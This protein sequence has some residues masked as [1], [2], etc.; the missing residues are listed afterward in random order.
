MGN[1]I[2]VD[3]I[4]EFLDGDIYPKEKFFVNTA[5]SFNNSING[6][7]SFCSSKI[8]GIVSLIK[9]SKAS[10]LI[11]DEKIYGELSGFSD[12]PFLIKSSNPRLDFA[13]VVKRFFL[14]EIEMKIDPTAIISSDAEIDDNVYIGPLSTIGKDVIIKKGTL[15]HAGVHIYDKVIIGEN[16]VIHSGTVIGADGFGYEKNSLGEMEKIPHIG[17]IIIEDNV[18]IGANTCIDRGTLDDTII[19]KGAKI[20]NLVHIAHNVD[21]GENCVVIANSMVAG[22]VKIGKGSWIAP[23]VNILNKKNIGSNAVIGIGSLVLKNVKD[24][25]TVYGFPAVEKKDNSSENSE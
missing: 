13:R 12:K 17:G 16:V 3:D 19:R 24:D 5:K 2:I 10:L 15:I 14:P 21:I 1:K 4:V 6:S 25:T 18:E 7:V 22:S 11:V 8:D 23:S 20:D 9:K